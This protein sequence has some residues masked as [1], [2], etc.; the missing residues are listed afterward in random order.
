MRTSK[1]LS[2]NS[3]PQHEKIREIVTFVEINL[4]SE[5]DDAQKQSSRGGLHKSVLESLQNLK[6]NICAGVSFLTKLQAALFK[7]TLRQWC[8]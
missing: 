8:F 2:I 6:E 1:T 4:W 7:K 5:I 3:P